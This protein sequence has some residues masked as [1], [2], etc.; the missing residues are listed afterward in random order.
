MKKESRSNGQKNIKSGFTLLELLV[1]VLIIGIL[2]AIAL[3]QYRKSVAKA[4]LAQIVMATKSIKSASERYYLVNGE[5]PNNINNLDVTVGSNINCGVFS[6]SVYCYNKK[7]ALWRSP[8]SLECAAK[9]QDENSAL[10]DACK[11]FG[12]PKKCFL[13]SGSANCA[14]NLELRPCFVCQGKT[15]I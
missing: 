15:T 7:F 3:P 12:T 5:Y 9:T 13:S 10:A 14:Y 2:A 1:A 4:E 8:N 11:N 6:S